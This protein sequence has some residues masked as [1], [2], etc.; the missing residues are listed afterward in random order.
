M[1]GLATRLLARRDASDLAILGA[2]VQAFTHLEAMLA[3]RPVKTVRVWNR[4]AEHA[5]QFAARA[6]KRH[7]IPVHAAASPE[8]AVTSSHKPWLCSGS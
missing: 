7:G 5:K 3:V 1:S 8:A 4:S 2:G 6:T